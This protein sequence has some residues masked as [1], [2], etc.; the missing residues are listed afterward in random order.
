MLT[1]KQ[2]GVPG[3]MMTGLIIALLALGLAIA[4]PPRAFLP[5]YIQ[6]ATPPGDVQVIIQRVRHEARAHLDIETD[7]I[8]PVV[9]RL[10]NLGATIVSRNDKRVVIKPRAGIDSASAAR[11]VEVSTREPSHG[12]NAGRSRQTDFN[13][14]ATNQDG[15]RCK[16]HSRASSSKI[17]IALCISILPCSALR[18]STTSRWAS[19]VG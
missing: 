19:F 18:R 15:N 1:D 6:P 12:S 14:Q 13:R 16:S 9:A 8:E 3:G 4:L 11:I 7:P 5:R 17:R 10:E 2:R